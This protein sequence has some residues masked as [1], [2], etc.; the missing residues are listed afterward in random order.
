MKSIFVLAIYLMIGLGVAN[1]YDKEV[2]CVTDPRPLPPDKCSNRIH[3]LQILV[4]PAA[5]GA[6]LENAA[7]SVG[8]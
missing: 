5:L 7:R 1:Q 2:S 4:W 3:D 6:L 8:Q